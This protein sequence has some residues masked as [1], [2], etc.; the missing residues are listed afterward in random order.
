[1]LKQVASPIIGRL[2]SHD[3]EF[4][5]VS[6]A[7]ALAPHPLAFQSGPFIQATSAVL[8]HSVASYDA[9][10]RIERQFIYLSLLCIG[11]RFTPM[12]N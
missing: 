5:T 3:F 1:M 2:K 10:S 9:V 12:N 11:A 6:L 8:W 7:F 4:K